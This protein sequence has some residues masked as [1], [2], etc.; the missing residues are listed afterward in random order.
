MLAVYQNSYYGGTAALTE[1]KVGNG[2]VLHLGSTFSRQNVRR[3][4]EYT[5]VCEPFSHIIDAPEEVE[6]VMRTKGEKSFLFALN[7]HPAPV[8]IE[9]K[10]C[11]KDLYTDTSAEGKVILPAYGTAVYE[12]KR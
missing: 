11:V 2:R 3:L 1:N 5:G 9:L 7:Y 6:L 12:I 10:E 8:A 4:L